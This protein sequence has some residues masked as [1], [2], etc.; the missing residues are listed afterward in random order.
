MGGGS[1]S[2]HPRIEY[3]APQI[4]R[5][6]VT[7]AAQFL[8]GSEGE[9]VYRQLQQAVSPEADPHLALLTPAQWGY[10]ETGQAF[11]RYV[12]LVDQGQW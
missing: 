12:A 6:V 11:S 5:Q 10:V 7:G 2:Q 1:G 4:H 9:R 8:V 3:L